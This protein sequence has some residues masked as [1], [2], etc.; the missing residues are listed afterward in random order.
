MGGGGRPQQT[1]SNQIKKQAC[2]LSRYARMDGRL[3]VPC[4]STVSIHDKPLP[5]VSSFRPALQPFPEERVSSDERPEE[6]VS[7]DGG[8][9]S[10]E[11]I[12][13]SDEETDADESPDFADRR[14]VERI[15]PK[16]PVKEKQGAVRKGR[17]KATCKEPVR[18][19]G[20]TA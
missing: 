2:L 20:F 10:T 12:S 13:L 1:L 4:L 19:Q 6:H 14:D 8:E 3:P 17:I 16:G 15:S 5:Y 9:A 7:S 18:S 11:A